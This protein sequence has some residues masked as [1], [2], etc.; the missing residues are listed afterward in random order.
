M[1]Y[2]LLLTLKFSVHTNAELYESQTEIKTPSRNINN[3]RYADDITPM[4]ETEE[5][6]MSLLVKVKQESEKAG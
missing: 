2:F 1:I 5:E 6:L 3:L 4:A